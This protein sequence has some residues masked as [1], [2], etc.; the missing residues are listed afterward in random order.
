[1]TPRFTISE[2]KE[3][4]AMWRDGFDT[5]DIAQSLHVPEAVIYNNRPVWRGKK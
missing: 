5:L 4:L 3:A 1:M 2:Q